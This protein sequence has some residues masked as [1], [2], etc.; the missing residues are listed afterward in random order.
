MYSRP[1]LE[2]R[3]LCYDTFPSNEKC[4]YNVITDIYCDCY[5]KC[6]LTAEESSLLSSAAVLRSITSDSG[7]SDL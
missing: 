1:R 7:T 4:C 5:C 3:G 2:N 6:Y